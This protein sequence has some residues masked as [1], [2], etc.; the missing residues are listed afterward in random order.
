MNSLSDSKEFYDPD[1]ASSSGASHVTSRP[2]T[3]PDSRT[4]LGRD[5]GLPPTT[6]DITGNV[7]DRLPAQQGHPQDYFEYSQELVSSSRGVK[8]KMQNK[9]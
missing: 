5:S 4:L 2:L 1:T 8:P 9:L 3:I 7:F 6:R